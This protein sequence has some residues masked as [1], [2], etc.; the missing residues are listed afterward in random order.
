M[1]SSSDSDP[2]QTGSIRFKR[3]RLGVV[4]LGV[5][6][7]LAFAGASAY[8]AWLSYRQ[9]LVAT[10]REIS[11]VAHALA[12]QTAWT[13]QAVDLLLRDTAR[14]YR[15]ESRGIPAER[16]DE[17]L[18]NRTVGVRQVRLV[19]IVDAQGFQRHRS[20]GSSP[21]N[22][23]VSDRSYFIAQRDRTVTGLFMSEPII[24]RSEN[25]AGVVLSR[26]LEDEKGGFA[27]VVTGS[28]GSLAPLQKLLADAGFPDMRAKDV[29]T[30]MGWLTWGDVFKSVLR[31]AMPTA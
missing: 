31:S 12:E 30:G 17:I 3:L 9:A 14:W 22:L 23:N 8:D 24:T 15:N 6:V 2:L 10:D 19:T 5:L 18:A 29:A 27:G 26:R 16:L 20:R 1:S 11:N 25:R 7:I 4:A 28:R 13:W 21:P